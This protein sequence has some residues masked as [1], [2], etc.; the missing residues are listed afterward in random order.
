MS[1]NDFLS[2]SQTLKS[3]SPRVYFIQSEK[4]IK[5]EQSANMTE[6]GQVDMEDPLNSKSNGSSSLI[7]V[8]GKDLMESSLNSSA[9][10]TSTENSFVQVTDKLLHRGIQTDQANNQ[11]LAASSQRSPHLLMSNSLS[12]SAPLDLIQSKRESM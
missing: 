10:W 3:P 9:L 12:L 4:K 11:V 7:K 8:N 1:E 6:G 5:L 2:S